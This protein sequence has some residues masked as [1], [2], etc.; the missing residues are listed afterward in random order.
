LILNGK[1]LTGAYLRQRDLKG[2][3]FQDAILA[4]ADLIRADARRA[5]FLNADFFD[6]SVDYADF[7]EADLRFAKFEDASVSADAK[8]A[9]AKVNSQTCWPQYFFDH[10]LQEAGLVPVKR[11]PADQANPLGHVCGKGEH[12][13]SGPSRL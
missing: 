2:T 7:R 5:N 6:A 10:G 13:K 12:R 11:N 4:Q 9:G 1:D 8:F 3:Q